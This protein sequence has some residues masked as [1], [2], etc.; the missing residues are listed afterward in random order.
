MPH[1]QSTAKRISN[2]VLPDNQ[3]RICSGNYRCAY[4][5]NS[6]ESEYGFVEDFDCHDYGVG[7]WLV[8]TIWNR[9]LFEDNRPINDEESANLSYAKDVQHVL[10][11]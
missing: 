2:Q 11:L 3:N 8:G 4:S 7:C 1:E 9:S 6:T 10:L 5:L